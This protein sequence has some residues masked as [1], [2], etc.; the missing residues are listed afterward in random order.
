VQARRSSRLDP[1]SD[2]GLLAA[3]TIE[4]HRGDFTAARSGPDSALGREPSDAQAWQELS[5]TDLALH[6]D[7]ERI[8][9]A[10]RGAGRRPGEPAAIAAAASAELS[11]AAPAGSATATATPGSVR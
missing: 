10:Q 3:A 7:A 8:V 11:L 1:L 5:Y 4:I 2:A 6:R 9:A